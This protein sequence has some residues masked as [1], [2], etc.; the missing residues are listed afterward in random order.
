MY[1][2]ASTMPGLNMACLLSRAV[3]KESMRIRI[4]KEVK[5]FP[6]EARLL[7]RRA[8]VHLRKLINSRAPGAAA[9]K[10][11]EL[12]L[13]LTDNQRIRKINQKW[14]YKDKATDVLS[15]PQFEPPMLR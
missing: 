1:C 11:T 10:K 13:V 6:Q 3:L 15:F 5:K 14:R 8:L 2:W 12:S 4:K 7:E 9:L